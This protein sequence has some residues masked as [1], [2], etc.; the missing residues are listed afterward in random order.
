[1]IGRL[2]L[3][4]S[5]PR[6]VRIRSA[7]PTPQLAPKASGGCAILSTSAAIPAEVRP[8]IVRPAVS[9]LIVPHHGKPAMVAASAAAAYSSK[10]DMVSIHST[11]APPAFSASACSWKISTA[12]A[13]VIVPMGSKI[14]PVGPIDP[15]TTTGRPAT[16]AISRPRLAA[17][18]FNSPTRPWALCSFNRAAL[19]PKELVRNRSDPA[20]T[21]LR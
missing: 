13:W 1:M 20:C 21:A 2:V 11:S 15:A 9:K 12:R 19:P 4:I 17:T 3:V 16:S 18:R 8:I 5:N 7:A 10:A 6:T 14:S